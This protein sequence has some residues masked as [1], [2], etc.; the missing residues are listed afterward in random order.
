MNWRTLNKE[1]NNLTEEQVLDLLRQEA[2]GP[3][4]SSI[5]TRLHQRYT[6]LRAM[7]ERK[8]WLNAG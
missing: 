2:Q 8:E 1:I 5:I 3:R 4:R 7:R 6:I